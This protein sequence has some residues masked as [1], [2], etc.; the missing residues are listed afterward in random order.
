MRGS[1]RDTARSV[2]RSGPSPNEDSLAPIAEMRPERCE[3]LL[4]GN[5]NATVFD[6]VT[7]QKVQGQTLNLF[8]VEQLPVVPP[9]RYEHVSFGPKTAAEVVREAVL[10]LTYT[11]H[12]MAP[13]ARDLGYVDKVGVAKPPF[14]WDE[15]RRLRLRAKLDVETGAMNGCHLVEWFNANGFAAFEGAKHRC[16]LG[17]RS[18]QQFGQRRRRH[19][20]TALGFVDR[21]N[22]VIHPALHLTDGCAVRRRKHIQSGI[23]QAH[24]GRSIETYLHSSFPM[25]WSSPS[26][27]SI[28]AQSVPA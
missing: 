5:L 12:D 21:R 23:E 17:A 9:E 7:R 16:S 4:A 28:R 26:G 13:F 8:I 11:A 25:L 27:S 14:R 10:E 20:Y 2:R 19:D 6:F 22:Q 18:H 24:Q 15:E 1:L 3:W